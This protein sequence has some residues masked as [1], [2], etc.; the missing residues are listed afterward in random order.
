LI[1]WSGFKTLSN[2]VAGGVSLGFV[3]AGLYTALKTKQS[4]LVDSRIRFRNAFIVV[5]A[6]LIGMTLIVEAIPLERQTIVS[7]QVLQRAS[8]FGL[9]LYFLI[10]NFEIRSGFSSEI[11][12][13]ISSVDDPLLMLNSNAHGGQKI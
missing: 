6:T 8:I 4:D 10:S 13:Q 9:T 3:L 1:S 5:T 2:S 12:C 7:L 11:P